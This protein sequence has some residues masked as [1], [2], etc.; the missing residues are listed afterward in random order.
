MIRCLVAAILFPVLAVAQE[1][2]D[3]VLL[4]TV[5]NLRPANMGVYGYERDTTPFLS[6]IARECAVFESA[7]STSA[8]TSPGM[9][10]FFTG[11]WPPTHAQSGQ[12]SWWDPTVPTAVTTF[13]DAGY[14]ATGRSN[15]GPTYANLGFQ[16]Q[17]APYAD[18]EEF[19]ENRSLPDLLDRP[20][21]GWMH[22][23]D[24]HLPYSKGSDYHLRLWGAEPP[25]NEAVGAVNTEGVLYVGEQSFTFT[26]EDEQRVRGLYDASVAHADERIGRAFEDLER[27]GLLERTLVIVSA[28]HGEEQFEHGWLG[29]A[30]TAHQAKLFD[31]NWHIPLIAC[32]PGGEFAGRYEPMVQQTMSSSSTGKM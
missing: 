18:L 21:F 12:Y 20:F 25:Y 2:P 26:E 1:A 9:S 32:F 5:D 22:L 16:Y 17:T 19:I 23:K 28:D 24:V 27:A 7:W 29:H 10:S 13:T 30:S 31:E 11:Y 4:I 6:S 3:N 8:W 15:S 14:R